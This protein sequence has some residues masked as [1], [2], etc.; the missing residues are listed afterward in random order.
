MKD[1]VEGLESPSL[2]SSLLHV[3]PEDYISDSIP[4]RFS[5]FPPLPP[6]FH[7][8]P[9]F[10]LLPLPS[11]FFPSPLP[12]FLSSSSL[13]L[14]YFF[15]S[16]SLPLFSLSLPPFSHFPSLPPPFLWRSV[17]FVGHD[18]VYANRGNDLNIPS[19]LVIFQAHELSG[20]LE[21]GIL[22]EPS[23]PLGVGDIKTECKYLRFHG[24]FCFHA[25]FSRG[26][27]AIY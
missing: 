13:L 8:L 6:P 23:T 15:L 2:D 11:F 12:P 25:I 9:L 22:A 4:V 27:K 3:P 17:T 16:P 5:P 26:K 18:Q 20:D 1:H 19:C 14:P 24:I 21:S 10:A 7:F